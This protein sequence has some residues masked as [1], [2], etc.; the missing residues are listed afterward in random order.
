MTTNVPHYPRPPISLIESNIPNWNIDIYIG[1]STGAAD[2]QLLRE[3]NITTVLNCAVNLD[4]DLVQQ[5]D[6]QH[7][8]PLCNFGAGP[9]RY[10]KIGL[11]DGDG[12]PE[13]MILAGYHLMRSSL[14]Q[15]IPEKPSYKVREKGN[16]LVHC[17]GGRSR[18][19]TIVAIFLHL[20]WPEKFPTLDSAIAHIR[21]K[22][23]LHPD[24]WFE[25]P[26]P[27][28]IELA[29]RAVMMETSLRQA[30]FGKETL[31]QDL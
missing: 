31:N 12:N 20:E 6:A 21:D 3:H 15:Q 28:L 22:R 1:G 23:Q 5:L 24:E 16:I 25:T 29:H 14:S 27:M 19:V 9:I 30:G 7:E 26:K 18:S 13:S 4:I 2:A 8:Q 17:R 10:Y 11:I